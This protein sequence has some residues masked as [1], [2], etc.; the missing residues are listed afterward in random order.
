[1]LNRFNEPLELKAVTHLMVTSS[2]VVKIVLVHCCLTFFF[3]CPVQVIS[4]ETNHQSPSFAFVSRY[5]Q[6]WAELRIN[7]RSSR[8]L[9]FSKA[10]K[11]FS[12][13]IRRVLINEVC[14]V[15]QQNNMIISSLFLKLITMMAHFP[16]Y[17]LEQFC[18]MIWK[19]NYSNSP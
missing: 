19:Q 17:L 12:I 18:K 13:L 14:C 5:H 2:P 15:H 4:L 6:C 1:M 9:V 16:H 10:L 7:D 3:V 11:C 8:M